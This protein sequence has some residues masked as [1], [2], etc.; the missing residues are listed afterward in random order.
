MVSDNEIQRY[1]ELD[2]QAVHLALEKLPDLDISLLAIDEIKLQGPEISPEDL[3]IEDGSINK[4]SF[5]NKLTEQI[6]RI[7][8]EAAESG[9]SEI[10]SAKIIE[11]FIIDYTSNIGWKD[12]KNTS[13]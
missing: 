7:T 2:L 10:E 6:F 5:F 9:V 8:R 4:E 12:V 3:E 1:S 11:D 13:G